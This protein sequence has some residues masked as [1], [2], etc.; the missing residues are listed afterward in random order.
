MELGVTLGLG[1]IGL[2]VSRI[3]GIRFSK[4]FAEPLGYGCHS[5]FARSKEGVLKDSTGA[6]SSFAYNFKASF[7]AP[8]GL[9]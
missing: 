4:S 5:A 9:V 1:S 7:R 3:S 2:G 6:D 8:K